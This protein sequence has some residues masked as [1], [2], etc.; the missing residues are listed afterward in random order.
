M[1]N[2]LIFL[3]GV[4][5]ALQVDNFKAKSRVLKVKAW[6]T[7]FVLIIA[8][9]I[10]IFVQRKAER[11]SLNDKKALD[12]TADARVKISTNTILDGFGKAIGK[13]S[14][15]YDSAKQE[16]VAL[17]KLIKGSA[18]RK[19]TIIQGNNPTV[20]FSDEGIKLD[21]LVNDKIFFP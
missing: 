19:T 1:I 3:T 13:Y 11:N 18:N 8:T 15:G 9:A 4:A 16:I 14:L 2:L 20:S 6:S 17:Q 10:S 12:S 21:S 5:A 7:L